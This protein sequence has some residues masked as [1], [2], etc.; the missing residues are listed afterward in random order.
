MGFADA[1]AYGAEKM[2]AALRF[3]HLLRPNR[4]PPASANRPEQHLDRRD[5]PTQ[6]GRRC[7]L[8]PSIYANANR[9]CA[10]FMA[11]RSNR[12]G[13]GFRGAGTEDGPSIWIAPR[14]RDA[15]IE[16]QSQCRNDVG[17]NPQAGS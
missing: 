6:T 2:A 8:F 15:G 10:A 13:H 11:P 3:L 4:R 1:I 5:L 17:R 9:S 12:S 14:D 16:A 7:R